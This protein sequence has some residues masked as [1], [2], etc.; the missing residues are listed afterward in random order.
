[1]KSKA[2]FYFVLTGVMAAVWL[3]GG[4]FLYSGN[5]E[6]EAQVEALRKDARDTKELEAELASVKKE[7]VENASKLAH[8]EKGIPELAYVPTMLKEL[9][10]FGKEHGINVT[11]VR[12]VPKAEPRG[13]SKE[14]RK[15]YQELTIEVKG[16]GPYRSVMQFTSALKKFPKIVAARTINLSPK[17]DQREGEANGPRNLDVTWE[18]RAFLFKPDKGG[19]EDV[20]KYESEIRNGKTSCSDAKPDGDAKQPTDQ[21]K[22]AEGAKTALKEGRHEG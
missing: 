12:P 9:E 5:S 22:P 11:G 15:P 3:G 8:L 7:A 1:M 2:T 18:L 19:N 17:N 10:A 13:K 16:R 20:K 6:K 4:F 14:E 21:P